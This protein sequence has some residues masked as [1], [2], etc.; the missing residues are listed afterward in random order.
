MTYPY[1][2]ICHCIDKYNDLIRESRTIEERNFRVD[3]LVM[4]M[5]KHKNFK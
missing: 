3:Q 2:L 4:Y 5:N 1:P